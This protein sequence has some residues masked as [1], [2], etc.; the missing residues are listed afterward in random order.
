MQA[1]AGLL[2]CRQLRTARALLHH[3]AYNRRASTTCDEHNEA[4]FT[5][6]HMR[7]G[8]VKSYMQG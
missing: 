8:G 7:A 1:H 4:S 5:L 2:S 6:V 3:S